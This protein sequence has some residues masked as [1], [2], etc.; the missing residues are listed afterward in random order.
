MS[1][2]A[3]TNNNYTS[4]GTTT[5]HWELGKT[6]PLQD[7]CEEMC[8]CDYYRHARHFSLVHLH[9]HNLSHVKASTALNHARKHLCVKLAKSDF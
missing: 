7:T 8:I 3:T 6:I 9:I 5:T 1:K 4:E 2:R